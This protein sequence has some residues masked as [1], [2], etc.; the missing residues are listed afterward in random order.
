M[1]SKDYILGFVEG[2]GCFFVAVQKYIDRKP[3]VTCRKNNVSY[4]VPF[5]VKVG[6]RVTNC[7]FGIIEELRKAFGF[8]SI[9]VQKRGNEKIRDTGL[10]LHKKYGRSAQG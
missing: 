9:Q 1:L 8:G 7:D 3:R 4:S 6:F 5:R 2:E 10:F